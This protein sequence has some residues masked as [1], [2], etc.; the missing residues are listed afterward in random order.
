M[1]VSREVDIRDVDWPV[2]ILNCKRELSQ[3]KTGE[4]IEILVKDIDVVNNLMALV[5]QL[6]GHSMEKQIGNKD[7]RLIIRKE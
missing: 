5:E 3:M 2:C 1:S 6:S 4:Q 7:Y